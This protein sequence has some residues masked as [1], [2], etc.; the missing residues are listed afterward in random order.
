MNHPV[1]FS[2]GCRRK[3]ATQ[4]KTGAE[5]AGQRLPLRF[6]IRWRLLS[7][8]QQVCRNLYTLFTL[9]EPEDQLTI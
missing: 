9:T 8:F 7:V 3:A 1:G 2:P 5:K 6:Q 4:G